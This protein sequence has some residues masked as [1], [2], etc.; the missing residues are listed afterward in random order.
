M[1]KPAGFWRSNWPKL[2]VALVLTFASGSVDIVGYL[3]IYHFFTAHLTG[4]TVQLGH[5]AI[6]KNRLDVISAAAILAAFLIGSVCGRIIIEIGSRRR[7]RSIASVT[8]AIEILILVSV[9]YAV[10]SL[11]HNSQAPL[12][13]SGNPYWALALLSVAMGIQTATLTRIGPLTVHTTFVT[14][15]VNKLAQLVSHIAFRT[16]DLL[17]GCHGVEKVRHARRS[18]IQKAA[19]LFAVWAFY[20]GGA[21]AGTLSFARW[22]VHALAL[23]AVLMLLAIFTDQAFPLST[24]EEEEEK[25]ALGP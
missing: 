14:G 10:S 7:I 24:Q 2:F 16:Y 1:A 21:M 9:A 17:H 25:E 4:T 5:N 3:G 6:A 15:M 13:N 8:L 11:L 12:A 20:A 18:D 19:F 23:P 22:G